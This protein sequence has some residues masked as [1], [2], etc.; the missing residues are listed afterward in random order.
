MSGR[1]GFE[2]RLHVELVGVD[3][4]EDFFRGLCR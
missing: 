3:W 1:Y 2:V 4:S